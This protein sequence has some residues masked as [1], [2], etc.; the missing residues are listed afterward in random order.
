MGTSGEDAVDEAFRIERG[1]VVRAFA[2]ADEFDG[3]A[4]HLL[5]DGDIVEI[6]HALGGG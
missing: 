4:E 3:H 5:R 6:V 1:E 2:Q